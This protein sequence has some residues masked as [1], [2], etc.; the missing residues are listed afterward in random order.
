MMP[1][2]PDEWEEA[3]EGL[4]GEE[5][6]KLDA[7]LKQVDDKVVHLDQSRKRGKKP[8]PAPPP[9]GWPAW[10][11]RL[12]RDDRGRVVADLANVMI[13]LRGEDKLAEACAFDE[14]LQHSIV[15]KPWPRLPDAGPGQPP[16]HKTDDDDIGRLQEW[17]QRMG[18]PR[19]GRE[20]VGQA[21]EL[22]GASSAFIRCAN[23][24]TPSNGTASVGCR[25][26]SG[27]TSA[28]TA[29]TTISARSAL[30]SSSPWSPGSSSPDANATTC[31]SSKAIK[32]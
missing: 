25:R 29:T 2:P 13:A 8:P 27:I 17:L 21:V 26:G 3:V 9:G 19:I 16:P 23:G 1:I 18:I 11:T 15:Q 10:A 31:S 20:I 7:R 6:K 24:S 30:C 22:R 32:G 12:R 14:M 4:T 28:R 5:R